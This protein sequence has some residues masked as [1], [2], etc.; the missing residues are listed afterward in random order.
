VTADNRAA[1]ASL[2]EQISAGMRSVGPDYRDW[3]QA[4]DLQLAATTTLRH[5]R[6]DR[7]SAAKDVPMA[8]TERLAGRLAQRPDRVRTRVREAARQYQTSLDALRLTDDQLASSSRRGSH[9]RTVL[10]AVL[11]VLLIPYAI[12][13]ALAVAIPYLL[14]QATRLIPAAP[15]VRATILPIVALLAFLTEWVWLSVSVASRQ[16]PESGAVIALLLPAFAG[17]TVLVAERAVLLWRALRRWA[18][19]RRRGLSVRVARKQR[20]D[21]L[22]AVREAL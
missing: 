10:D 16:G 4:R 3:D 15:A 13:G 2:T 8:L 18:T 14:V 11:T 5:V 6:A 9:T 7:A 19:S 17:A 1:V 12:V 21:L 22:V 20:D